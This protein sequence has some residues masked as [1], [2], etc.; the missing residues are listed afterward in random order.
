MALALLIVA[1]I[2]ASVALSGFSASAFW[3]VVSVLFLGHAMDQ[4]GL[5]RRIAYGILLA[6]PATYTG[7]LFAFFVIGFVLA[8]GIPS[9]T[10]RTAI[11]VPI[12]WAL[13]K[14]LGIP[15]PSRGSAL[16]ILS[17]FEMAVLP[18][19]AILTGAL[20]G[21]YLAGLFASQNLPISWLG[22]AKVMA[23]PTMI[24]CVLILVGNRLTLKPR[25]E[26]TVGREVIAGELRKLGPISRPELYTA[27][28][29]AVS[30]AAWT[31]QS[32]H[33]LPTEAVGMIA[34]TALFAGGVLKTSDI[35]NGI[36]WPLV[37]FIGGQLSLASVMTTYKISTWLAAPMVSLLGSVAG[38]PMLFVV[39]LAIGVMVLRFLDPDGFIAIGAFFLALVGVA[40]G[41]GFPPLV[42]AGI[43]ILPLHVFWFSY[44]NIWIIMTEG[45]TKRMAH[46]NGD[47]VR[48]ALVYAIISIMSL[49]IALG[50]WKLVRVI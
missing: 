6:F 33:R 7:M 17:T 25:E 35:A 11:M 47:R 28:V 19:C 3:I 26:L 12:A 49:W 29:G 2:P 34:M 16:I 14:A 38:S 50:Y 8:F 21:P 43:I 45:M 42:L 18:G 27:V 41:W 36:S 13:V 48:L 15:L 40:P 5:A 9:M 1:G 23:I 4:T 24:W 46:T 10:V 44:Q 39:L 32:W 31:S 20:W 30:L 22:Y 37:L